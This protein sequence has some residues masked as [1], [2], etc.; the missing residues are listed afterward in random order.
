M[1][2]PYLNIYSYRTANTRINGTAGHEMSLSAELST[3][4][5]ENPEAAVSDNCVFWVPLASQSTSIS[6]HWQFLDFIFAKPL[7]FTVKQP[8]VSTN[9]GGG[10][11]ATR[12][13][14]EV[15]RVHL[16]GQLRAPSVRPFLGLHH[17][18]LPV[19]S[20]I[21]NFPPQD[22]CPDICP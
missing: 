13:K 2:F 7:S 10:M 4:S 16:A 11:I 21:L 15:G 20:C 3:S 6:P 5:P 22:I 12:H 19:R 8:S 9:A 18:T 17:F 14:V 1:T